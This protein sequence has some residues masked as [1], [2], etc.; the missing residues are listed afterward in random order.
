MDIVTEAGVYFN[1]DHGRKWLFIGRGQIPRDGEGTSVGDL[2][3]DHI[4]DIVAPYKTGT[5]LARF[6][7]PLHHHGDPTREAWAA[8]IIDA[9][10]LFTGN[11]TTAIGDVNG[12]GR[13]DIV[14]APMYGGG[15]L[16]VYEAPPK[17]D[18]IWHRRVIDSTINFVHQGSLQMAD[19]DDDGHLDIAFAEQDQSPTQRIGIF[20]NLNGNA[21]LWRL[22]VLSTEGG[23]NI[24]VGRIANDRSPSIL[25]ARHGFFGGANPLL[26]FRNQQ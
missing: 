3:G 12:D 10:P 1:R 13:N 25:S 22:Q 23:H 16:V 18:G 5:E 6:V 9:H 8:Q 2:A 14:L 21:M 17:S 11:M 20:Y 19:F 24:K 26:L 7:N 4:P 15:G